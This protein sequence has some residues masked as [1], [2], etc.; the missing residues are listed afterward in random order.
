MFEALGGTIEVSASN[1]A[2]DSYAIQF[3]AKKSKLVVQKVSN[4]LLYLD[5]GER[6]S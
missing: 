3:L 6:R 5:V 4:R 2:V 1:D